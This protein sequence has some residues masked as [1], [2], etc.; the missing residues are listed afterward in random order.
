M[1]NAS[2]KWLGAGDAF[3]PILLVS[4]VWR[5]CDE[6][7]VGVPVETETRLEVL[8]GKPR[9]RCNGI[10]T[11]GKTEPV[12]FHHERRNELEMSCVWLPKAFVLSSPLLG[13]WL[14][15]RPKTSQHRDAKQNGDRPEKGREEAKESS[16]ARTFVQTGRWLHRCRLG[17]EQRCYAEQRHQR[18]EYEKDYG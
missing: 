10:T 3:G 2:E 18:P 8:Q 15:Q 16:E 17:V 4:D 11:V 9:K 6:A 14:P 12:L 1:S 7:E 5:A 13:S